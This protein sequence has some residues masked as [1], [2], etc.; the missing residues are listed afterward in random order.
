MKEYRNFILISNEK[1]VITSSFANCSSE[2]NY[3]VYNRAFPEKKGFNNYVDILKILNKH[4]AQIAKWK[5]DNTA[6]SVYYILIPSKLCKI[7][8]D[9][10][11][12]TW[13]DSGERVNGL[14]IPKEE[15]VQ[16]KLF[17]TLYKYVFADICFKPNNVYSK[18]NVNKNY[19]HV[20]FT[21]NVVDKMHNY[22]NQLKEQNEIKAIDDLLKYRNI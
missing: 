14:K 17:N 18:N 15:L 21:I 5:E 13:L 19:K 7:I 20:I 12:K 10:L 2:V 9:K 8:K 16:W 4:L 1:N 6:L 22:L 3:K 11:F